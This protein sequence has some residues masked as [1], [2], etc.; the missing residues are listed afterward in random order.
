MQGVGM[1]GLVFIA[2]VLLAATAGASALSIGACLVGM[3]SR[4][5]TVRRWVASVVA[6]L[7]SAPVAAAS[8]LGCHYLASFWGIGFAADYG[9]YFAVGGAAVAGLVVGFTTGRLLSRSH[10]ATGGKLPPS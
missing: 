4:K 5:T 9:V 10:E 3:K 6:G 8:A 2:L 7:V 1:A